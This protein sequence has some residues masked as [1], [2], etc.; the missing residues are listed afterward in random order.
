MT[1]RRSPHAEAKYAEK[2]KPNGMK[3]AGN[4]TQAGP[5]PGDTVLAIG[6]RFTVLE[7]RDR[8]IRRLRGEA[9]PAAPEEPVA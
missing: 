4:G 8:R 2:Q 3:P 9:L 7:V 6:Y 5:V 1:P